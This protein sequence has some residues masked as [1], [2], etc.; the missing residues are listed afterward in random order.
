MFRKC[1]CERNTCQN[2][3]KTLNIERNALVTS[4]IWNSPQGYNVYMH[5]EFLEIKH[6]F[7]WIIAIICGVRFI[8]VVYLLFFLKQQAVQFSGLGQNKMTAMIIISSFSYGD[9]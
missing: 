5:S 8:S 3:K 2:T 6:D 1:F 4:N 7:K 9:S